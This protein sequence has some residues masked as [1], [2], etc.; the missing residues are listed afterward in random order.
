MFSY[1]WVIMLYMAF[2]LGIE[3]AVE[4]IFELSNGNSWE[5]NLFIISIS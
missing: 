1:V 5:K 4:R 3:E 2:K